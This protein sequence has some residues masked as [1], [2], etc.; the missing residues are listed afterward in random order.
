MSALSQTC[1]F[2]Y[3]NMG[4]VEVEGY[5]SH[6][7]PEVKYSECPN[8]DAITPTG[9]EDGVCLYCGWDKENE[10]FEPH[11]CIPYVGGSRFFCPECGCGVFTEYVPLKYECNSC[12]AKF[13]GEEA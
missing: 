1:Q 6:F 10:E 13:E 4:I 9:P 12:G 3:E 11:D 8:C 7:H 5:L 2:M